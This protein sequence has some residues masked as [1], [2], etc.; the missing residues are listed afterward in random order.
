[1][2]SIPLHSPRPHTRQRLVRA[3]LFLLL[4]GFLL[5]PSA[6]AQQP[7]DCQLDAANDH[8]DQSEYE[9]A[10]E[11][12][13]ARLQ[14]L[15]PSGKSEEIGCMQEALHLIVQLY[16][17]QKQADELVVRL[18]QLLDIKPPRYVFDPEKETRMLLTYYYK[19]LHEKRKAEG[20]DNPDEVEK[21]DPSLY[22]I[23]FLDFSNNTLY[24]RELLEPLSL[25]VPNQVRSDFHGSSDVVVVERERTQWL[26]DEKKLQGSPEAVAPEVGELF[27]ARYVVFGSFTN[28]EGKKQLRV[29]ARVVRVATGEILQ[30]VEAHG[31]LK[32]L[33]ELT[34]DIS[35]ELAKHMEVS[36]SKAAVEEQ[37]R[38][39]STSTEAALAFGEGQRLLDQVVVEDE[40]GHYDL[41][42]E[43]LRAAITRFR[44]ALQHD[45]RY[46]K[47]KD[48]ISVYA[49]F[50]DE[51]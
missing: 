21:V 30:I 1:M 33:H 12:V 43:I 6:W 45:S 9:Q 49:S 18:E 7:N 31:S 38:S 44:E 40:N 2:T 23:A 27:G 19:V 22:T 39:S 28:Y 24:D 26:L 42:Q 36:L 46:A 51:G 13:E 3:S 25:V 20:F 8:F 10:I 5:A 14:V 11:V 34:K 37:R 48:I 4:T 32:R 35:L 17:H 29:Q 15:E 50:L 41:D 16:S 47:A